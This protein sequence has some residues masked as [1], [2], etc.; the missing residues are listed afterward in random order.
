[1]FDVPPGPGDSI[2]SLKLSGMF[3]LVEGG[4]ALVT[5]LGAVN[6]TSLGPLSFSSSD[7]LN[8]GDKVKEEVTLT[9]ENTLVLIS[10]FSLGKTGDKIILPDSAAVAI[11]PEPTSTLS[12]LVLGGL[13]VASTLKRKLKSS[14]SPEKEAEKVS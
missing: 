1:M 11:T 3:E 12:F 2:G 10:T 13:G 4:S 6:G 5:S 9:E 8:F 7:G 14:K